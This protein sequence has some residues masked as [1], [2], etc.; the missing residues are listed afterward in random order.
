MTGASMSKTSKKLFH[1]KDLNKTAKA[2]TSDKV[3]K[4]KKS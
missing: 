1:Y 4:S 3:K 2:K